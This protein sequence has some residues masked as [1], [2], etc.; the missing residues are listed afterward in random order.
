MEQRGSDCVVRDRW[1][2]LCESIE[3]VRI[4]AT[5]L[6]NYILQLLDELRY[7]HET[8]VMPDDIKAEY[9]RKIGRGAVV[10]GA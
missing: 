3:M 5:G 1:L 7:Y 10:N 6:D 8:G 4:G 9:E 2:S